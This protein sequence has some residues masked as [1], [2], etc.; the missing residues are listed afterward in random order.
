MT[1]ELK[2]QKEYRTQYENELG[3]I[4]DKN[5]SD[6]IILTENYDYICFGCPAYLIEIYT[7]NSIVT[8]QKQIPEN[9]YQRTS[10][11]FSENSIGPMTY[12]HADILE[13]KSEIQ[14]GE[15]WSSNP[16]KYGTDECFDGGHT[17]YTVF[18]PNGEIESMYMRCWTPEEFK[19]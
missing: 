4:I 3:E 15:N 18:Y 19:K 17:F 12:L 1:A 5:K 13:L 11:Q 14:K 7:G 9:Q 10:I 2:I 6:T 16:E 8:Y